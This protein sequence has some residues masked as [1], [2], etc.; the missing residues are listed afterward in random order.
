[1]TVIWPRTADEYRALAEALRTLV[2]GRQEVAAR[3]FDFEGQDGRRVKGWGP[4]KGRRVA[5]DHPREP[6]EALWIGR[7]HKSGKTETWLLKPLSVEHVTLHLRG[8][9][10]LGVYVLD[11][12]DCC[13]FL[14]A[15]FDDHAGRLDPAGVWAEVS[16]FW[17]ICDAQGWRAHVERSKSGRGYHVWIFFDAPVAAGAARA[18]GRWLFEEAQALREGEDFATFDRFFPAQAAAPK[19]GRGFGNLIGLPLSGPTD[20]AAGRCA[21]VDPG[22]GEIL[23][24]PVAYT[25]GILEHGRNPA[26]RVAT[27]LAEQGLEPEAASAYEGPGRDPDAARGTADEWAAVVERCAFVRWAASEEVAASLV[28]P[29]WFDLVSQAARFEAEDWIHAASAPHPG[30]SVAELEIKL[31][32]ARTSAGPRGCKTI[33][34]DGCK[35]CPEGGCALPGG[36]MAGAPA[37]LAAWARGRQADPPAPHVTHRGRDRAVVLRAEDAGGVDPDAEPWG[38]KIPIHP[39]TGKPWPAPGGGWKLSA[40]GVADQRNELLCLRPLW[41]H[42]LTENRT[43]DDGIVVKWFDRR[44]RLRQYA[45]PVTIL[46]EPGGTLA[47]ELHRMGCLMVPGK[48]KWVARFLTVQEA[49]ADRFIQSTSQLGWTRASATDTPVFVLPNE[50]IGDAEEEIVYQSDIPMSYAETIKARGTL[51]EWRDQVANACTGNPILMFAAML[52][53]AAPLLHLTQEPGGGF[54]FYGSTTGG[55]TTAG[56]VAASVWGCAADPS[57]N[58]ERTSIRR[59]DVTINALEGIAEL[60][61]HQVLVLDEIGQTELKDVGQAAYKLAG[62]R[63][64]ERATASGGLQEPRRWR[65]LIVSNG[66]ISMRQIMAREGRTL[67]GGQMVRMADVPVDGDD[68][69]QVIVV[70]PHGETPKEFVERLKRACARVY[71]VPGRAFIAY[72]LAAMRTQGEGTVAGDL[73]DELAGVEKVLLAQLGTE[74]PAEGVRVL[75]RFALVALAGLRAGP[76]GACVLPWS[77]E[78]VLGAV[79]AVAQRWLADVG[80]DRSEIQRALAYLRDQLLAR[81]GAFVDVGSEPA[82]VQREILGWRSE[83]YVLVLP[84][85]F[86]QLC[87]EFE[88]RPVLAELARRGLL[89]TDADRRHLTRWTPRLKGLKT[90]PRVYWISVEFLGAREDGDTDEDYEAGVAQVPRPSRGAQRDEE[91]DLPL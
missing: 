88:P 47:G 44:W 3:F 2:G 7:D 68:G 45:L 60:H 63:G 50:V 1:M 80:E 29:L 74:L 38:P 10:R 55:K 41:V 69:R 24:D 36:K 85:A 51:G 87:G 73:K 75:K 86:R 33:R 27:W 8:K 26:A 62:G 91:D 28:E 39:D 78:Q 11:G 25:R 76:K 84:D 46:H 83:Q 57:E 58:S 14:A 65:V 70:D 9:E 82:P 13:A 19:T 42:A 64:K 77:L 12:Q 52:G 66:E 18:V 49:R 16:R 4:W 32:H 71:G 21:W 22:T 67:R 81:G 37:A 72:L 61:S 54:H 59:W 40:A 20:Y 6:G 53:L 35:V 79:A 15:D 90:R 56:Q 17:G 43:G 89:W 23:P 34:A 48:E 5:H 30:Y 31:E